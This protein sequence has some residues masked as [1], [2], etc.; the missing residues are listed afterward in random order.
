[1]KKNKL[2]NLSELSE[3][4]EVYKGEVINPISKI[5]PSVNKGDVVLKAIESLPTVVGHFSGAFQS[6]QITKQQ[7]ELTKQVEAKTEENI[8][9]LQNATTQL[10]SE[11]EKEMQKMKNEDSKEEREINLLREQQKGQREL[12]FQKL[13]AEHQK[14]IKKLDLEGQKLNI[15]SSTIE[16]LQKII[17][18]KISK[19][20]DYSLE[21]TQLIEAIQKITADQ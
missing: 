20:E 11:N 4:T 14:E 15:H 8:A 5:G 12:E 19:G 10:L 9:K 1:M 16:F 3:S 18:S 21:Q 17:E 7:I 2:G 13:E 6:V